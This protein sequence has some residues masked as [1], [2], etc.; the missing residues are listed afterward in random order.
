M[1]AQSLY[2]QGIRA[3]RD[4]HDLKLGH[5]LLKRSLELD[6]NN[7][8]AWL[9][10]TRTVGNPQTR[11]DY[12]E[13]ALA[14]NPANEDAQK[15]RSK[16]LADGVSTAP[17]QAK[18]TAP[19]TVVPPFV[20]TDEEPPTRAVKPVASP[21]AVDL[22]L[23]PVTKPKTIAEPLTA[24]ERARIIDLMERATMYL[25][26][27]DVEAAIEQWVEV[28]N[29]RVDHE[30]AL[31]NAAGHLWR[32]HYQDD[33]R[34]LIQRAIDAGTLVPT[35]YTTAIDMAE[36]QGDQAEAEI[37]REQIATLPQADD[38]LLITIVDYYAQR[39]QIQQATLFANQALATNPNRPELLLRMGQLLEDLNQPDEAN[40]YYEQAARLGTRS[41]ASREADK[42]LARA[43][44]V[45]TDRER[46]SV[47]L[48]VRESI[49]IVIF[50]LMLAWQDA[51]LN[52]LELGFRRW[53]GMV[54]SL[55]GG[56][57]LVTATSSPQQNPVAT[58]LGG[59]VPPDGFKAKREASYSKPGQAI[60]DPTELPI[61]P[62][63][64]RY[65]LGFAGFV[66]LALSFALVFHRSISLVIEN[67]PPY[68]FW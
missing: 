36:R 56:Y 21:P 15:L 27:D 60:Q 46:G 1:D 52:L 34:E 8:R 28:L 49:G 22:S 51:G 30:V 68:L 26:N 38:R 2:R 6:S 66:V 31:R 4:Q 33:A 42:K 19:F 39:F 14:I 50:W 29:I 18:S 23:V 24:D 48:A 53:L 59:Q 9:W 45:L 67:P 16:L 32:L 43:M 40:A 35:T 54:M 44:P 65:L 41:R 63:D 17:S 55:I 64:A 13:R 12:V 37:L 61:I 47:W 7:D 3:I 57:L 25:E 62:D 58:L 10:L 20:T 11:L 5:A